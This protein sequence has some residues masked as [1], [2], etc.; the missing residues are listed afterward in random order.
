MQRL[1]FAWAIIFPALLLS[2]QAK[3]GAGNAPCDTSFFYASVCPGQTFFIA[4]NIFD[5]QNP[6]GVVVLP[7]ASWDG[8]DSVVVVQLSLAPPVTHVIEGNFCQNEALYI[9]GQIYDAGHPSGTELLPGGAAGGCD[10]MIVVNLFFLSPA[11]NHLQQSICS[12]DTVWVNNQPYDQYYYLGMET[13]A[14]GAANGCDSV[15][16]VDLSVL[17]APTDTFSMRL[18][19]GEKIVI[20]GSEYNE[21]RPAGLEILPGA[22]ANGC[23]SL[24]Y[25]ELTFFDPPSIPAFL[26]QDQA[27]NL[28][29]SICISIP[30]DINVA[31]IRWATTLPCA[32]SDCRSVCFQA[33]KRQSLICTIT[34]ENQCVF[35]DTVR[36]EVTKNRPVYIPNVFSVEAAPPNN[37]FNIFPGIN[38]AFANWMVLYDRWGSLVY[39]VK[40]FTPGDENKGWDGNI[41]GTV[42]PPGVYAYAVEILYPD[43]LTEILSGTVTLVR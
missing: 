18:C 8:S 10:S 12:N 11:L 36:I 42:A 7:E 14:G 41:N 4:G 35:S 25:V 33:E 3:A 31:Q 37:R 32:D 27:A 30:E 5:F 34:D 6:D 16:L 29:D 2:F 39:S 38:G 13:I 20:I 1:L 43:G 17:P 40:D 9:N 26:G 28:G 19:P 15:I 21:T 23:D 24:V 22:A